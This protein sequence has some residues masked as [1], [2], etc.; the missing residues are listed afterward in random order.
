[1]KFIKKLKVSFYFDFREIKNIIVDELSLHDDLKASLKQK[2]IFL[3]NF[4]FFAKKG[5]EKNKL[6]VKTNNYFVRTRVF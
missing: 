6:N 2:E 3:K 5:N 1:M 4:N